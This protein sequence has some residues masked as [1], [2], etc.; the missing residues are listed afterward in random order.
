MTSYLQSLRYESDIRFGFFQSELISFCFAPDPCLS[1]LGSHIEIAFTGNQ[2]RLL[3]FWYAFYLNE[4][5]RTRA[6]FVRK[7]SL[8]SR[9]RFKAPAL[10]QINSPDMVEG[11]ISKIVILNPVLGR[12]TRDSDRGIEKRFLFSFTILP[13]ASTMY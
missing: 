5:K 12:K 4:E 10:R 7:G 9:K 6:H 2:L 1:L 11:W 13:L 8:C 3:V